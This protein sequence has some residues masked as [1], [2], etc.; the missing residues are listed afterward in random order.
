MAILSSLNIE[1]MTIKLTQI[2]MRALTNCTSA[3]TDI[4]TIIAISEWTRNINLIPSESGRRLNTKM[5]DA[6]DNI[7]Y[8]YQHYRS[9]M[10]LKYGINIDY[11]KKAAYSN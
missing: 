6:N 9:F 10:P 11:F 8:L 3:I 1:P 5:Y 2:L 7:K 4:I